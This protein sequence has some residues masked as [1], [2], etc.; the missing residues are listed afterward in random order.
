M[1][2][3]QERLND[4]STAVRDEKKSNW[5]EVMYPILFMTNTKAMGGADAQVLAGRLDLGGVPVSASPNMLT[6]LPK[7]RLIRLVAT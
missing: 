2:D 7:V 3:V 5:A 4:I 6:V 1:V